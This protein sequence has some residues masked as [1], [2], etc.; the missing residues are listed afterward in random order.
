MVD[1]FWCMVP[2]CKIFNFAF[3]YW[4]CM[5]LPFDVPDL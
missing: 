1:T 3:Y 4:P 2:I 5:L